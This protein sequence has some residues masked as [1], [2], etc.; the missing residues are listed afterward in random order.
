MSTCNISN[1]YSAASYLCLT[2]WYLTSVSSGQPAVSLDFK[3][4]LIN[5]SGRDFSLGLS[6]VTP[7]YL[8]VMRCSIMRLHYALRTYTWKFCWMYIPV[9]WTFESI[10]WYRL[11]AY[12]NKTSFINYLLNERQKILKR[13]WEFSCD[14]RL[15]EKPVTSLA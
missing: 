9:L 7:K 6:A 8:F 14:I 3:G 15:S 12:I 4:S 1:F 13:F 2:K 5:S 11:T 10:N